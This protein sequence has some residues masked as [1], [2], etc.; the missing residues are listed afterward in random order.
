MGKEW[1]GLIEFKY[2]TEDALTLTI[3][4]DERVGLKMAL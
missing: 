1:R 4:D 3:S 2:V